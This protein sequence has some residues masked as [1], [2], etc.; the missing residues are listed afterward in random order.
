VACP[1][2]IVV[3]VQDIYPEIYEAHI[4]IFDG[5]LVLR[6]VTKTGIDLYMYPLF[7][8]LLATFVRRK[9]S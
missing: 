8:R 9:D 1:I 5:L 4:P 7:Y 3:V 6:S 2:V